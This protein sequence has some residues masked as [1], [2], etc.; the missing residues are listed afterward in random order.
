ME[1][2]MKKMLLLLAILLIVPTLWDKVPIIK[3]GVSYVLDPTFGALIE[4]H[5]IVGF[6][7]TATT[8][9][10]FLTL[11]QKKFSDQEK[12]KEIKDKQK[13]IQKEMKQHQ[14][15]GNHDKVME[16]QKELFSHMGETFKHSMEPLMYTM[17]PAI[18][19]FRWFSHVL[20][21]HW[22]NWWILYFIIA[23]M[24]TGIVFRK[25]FDLA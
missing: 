21:P 9:S 22:G 14:K 10:L 6:I 16:L 17:V 7:I 24:A 11:A 20:E 15:D 19:F 18:L 13:S 25:V 3:E 8:L 5:L 2:H 12:L 23:S 4:W 1:G